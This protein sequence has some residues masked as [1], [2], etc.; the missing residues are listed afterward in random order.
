M[1]IQLPKQ[2]EYNLIDYTKKVLRN[3]YSLK[4]YHYPIVGVQRPQSLE[5]NGKTSDF[6]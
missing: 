2:N 4:L 5:I 1:A 6:L 3:W